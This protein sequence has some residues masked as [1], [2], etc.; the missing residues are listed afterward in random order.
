MQGKRPPCYFTTHGIQHVD[1]RDMH[2]LQKFLDTHGRVLSRRR[3]GLCARYQRRVQQ[4][5]KRAR[6]MALLPYVRS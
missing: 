4:A 1:Y 3:T 2:L 5:V 6:Y